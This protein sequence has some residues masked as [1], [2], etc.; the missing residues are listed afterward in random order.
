M[1]TGLLLAALLPAKTYTVCSPD[2]R[3][4]CTVS[5]DSGLSW[6]LSDG[7]IPLILPSPLSMTLSGA[8]AFGPGDAVRKETRTQVSATLPAAFYQ[9]SSVRDCCNQLVLSFK[10]FDLVVRVYDDAA[11]YRFVSRL[12]EER[13]VMAEQAV[14]RFAED[15]H[16]WIPYVA[17]HL[18]SLESQL[19]NSFENTYTYARLSAWDGSR[20]AFLPLVVEVGGRK[21]CITEADLRNYPGMYLYNVDGGTALEGRFARVP[22]RVEQGGHNRL[23]GVV[24]SRKRYIAEIS[25]EQAFPWR[26][27][28]V[29]REDRELAQNDIVWKLA[30]P[31]PN[32]QDYA[33][34]KPGKVAWDW[35]N[36]WNIYGVDFASGV[37]DATYRHYIDFAAEKGVEY[38]ILDE[39]WAVNGR[40]D[41]FAVVPEI[42][43]QELVDYARSKGVGIILWAGYWAFNQDMERVCKTYSE[44]GVKG[45]K[46][47]FMDR[48]DQ[49][50]V[51]FYERAAETAARY[52]L[53]LD[54]HG[55]Y[56]PTGLQ[57][58]WPNILN[59]EGV[60]GLEQLK[61]SN[62]D[63]PSYDASIPFIRLM[64]GPADYTQGAMR[65][66]T[67]E[68]FR[69]VNE[70]PMSQGTRCHQLAEYVV[71]FSPLN[72]L[73]DSPDNYR[74]EPACTGF[75]TSCPVVWDET[76]V[77]G[78]RIGD[79]IVTARRSGDTWYI[80][81]LTSWED[82]DIE[83][84]LSVFGSG[85]HSLEVFCDGANAHRVARDFAHE[86]LVA[87]L[88]RPLQ[89]HLAPGG[90]WVGILR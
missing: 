45:F 79:Y 37:N 46:V 11:A 14:F 77:L 76:R 8:L 26:V 16:A 85:V 13:T 55:A 21:L 12:K 22:D 50:M 84:D 60:H 10:E 6:S 74:A 47:D 30:T 17:Q 89:I 40:A 58:T 57:R 69:P 86:E 4:R 31:C 42:H 52:G 44:M 27:V 56:K 75:I 7:D 23:Q 63:Q 82:R 35:W 25:G 1:M 24:K 9:R 71:F 78:G 51:R 20:L 38:V 34:V 15:G 36:A 33:W 43:L 19:W 81:A 28:A 3:L 88:S 65:N 49:P 67:R 29:A 68:N 64:A 80:G 39:G 66:A 72:M 83:L 18:E 70:E 73:C 5:D 32:P 59:F 87:D 53:V 41:L 62:P 2:G 90:G 61:W 48:D 54:F